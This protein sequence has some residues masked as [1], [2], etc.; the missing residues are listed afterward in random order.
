MRLKF[1]LKKIAVG[2]GGNYFLFTFAPAQSQQGTIAQLVEHRTEN[3]GVPGSTPGGTTSL[4]KKWEGFFY[5]KILVF[6]F[7]LVR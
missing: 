5:V 3:P 6:Y 1:F 2:F 4:S 7:L